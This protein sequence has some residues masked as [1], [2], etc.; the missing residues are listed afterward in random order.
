MRYLHRFQ[1][2]KVEAILTSAPND[3][4]LVKLRDDLKQL[5]ALTK[6]IHYLCL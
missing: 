5:I 4:D 2:S 1:L 6:V 3:A